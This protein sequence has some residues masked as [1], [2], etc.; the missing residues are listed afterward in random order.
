MSLAGGKQIA[1]AHWLHERRHTFVFFRFQ[2]QCNKNAL[3]SVVQLRKDA[4]AGCKALGSTLIDSLTA[5][6]ATRSEVATDRSAGDVSCREVSRRPRGRALVAVAARKAGRSPWG[7]D[8]VLARVSCD[9]FQ[10]CGACRPRTPFQIL[11][12]VDR[13]PSTATPCTGRVAR[14]KIPRMAPSGIVVPALPVALRAGERRIRRRG[15]DDE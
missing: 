15:R 14:M 7:R 5:V 3:E 4:G 11:R 2:C 10:G 12:A 13:L 1:V 9:R 6:A 8:R